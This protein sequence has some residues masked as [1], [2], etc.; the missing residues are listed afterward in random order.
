MVLVL[1]GPTR[2]FSKMCTSYAGDSLIL[3]GYKTG[4]VA[5]RSLGPDSLAC[6]SHGKWGEREEEKPDPDS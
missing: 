6:R 5:C 1:D 4:A 3:N 2:L